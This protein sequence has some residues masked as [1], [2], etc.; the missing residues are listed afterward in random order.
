MSHHGDFDFKKVT[1][2]LVGGA[3][4]DYFFDIPPK[5]MDYVVVGSSP[6]EM[7]S[8]GFKQVGKDFPVFLHPVSGDEYALARTEQKVGEGHNGFTCEW[9]GVTLKEDLSRRDL[10][11]NSMAWDCSRDFGMMYDP[12]G[13]R[14]DIKDKVLRHTSEHFS[15]D[16]LRVL[17]VCRLLSRFDDYVNHTN[18]WKIHPDTYAL[19]KGIDLSSLTPERVWMEMEKALGE[20]N[21][22]VFFDKLSGISNLLPEWDDMWNTPQK[23]E[24][25]PEGNVGIHSGMAMD[26]AA[27]TWNDPEINMALLCHDAG[28]PSCWE[29]YQ[30]AHGHEKEGLPFIE[31]FCDKWK[32]PNK[33]RKLALLTCEFH[34]KVHGCLG[35]GSNKGMKPKSIMKLFEDTG[36][37]SNPQRFTKMLKACEADAK[38]RGNGVEQILEYENKPYPQRDYLQRCL[39]K[40]LTFKSGEMS[41]RLLAEGKSGVMIGDLLRQE[42][43]KLIRGVVL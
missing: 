10:T 39:D 18:S 36:A 42:K 20:E 40:V 37:L 11:I 25:H 31:D 16:P 3:V 24:H 28:K 43:I 34:T 9:E 15:E 21:P 35:R 41:K 1:I 17:R 5:D 27:K 6:S 12:F 14:Q 22:S 8:L 23:P 4:R 13:G 19:I 7:L 38:G 32:V 33:Y 2:Y 26:Y 29:K 30:N